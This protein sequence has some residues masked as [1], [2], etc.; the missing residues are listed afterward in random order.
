M[1]GMTGTA[2]RRTLDDIQRL[3]DAGVVESE[4]LDRLCRGA[5]ALSL[6]LCGFDMVEHNIDVIEWGDG[7]S[8]PIQ[9]H[10]WI[11]S[12]TK[13]LSWLLS[14]NVRR[15]P[16]EHAHEW[17]EFADGR[18]VCEVCVVCRIEAAG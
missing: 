10:R 18:S 4:L 16:F 6:C 1:D 13:D 8:E 7:E 3:V 17:T 14:V 2:E 5:D 15:E 11:P 9:D 12:R